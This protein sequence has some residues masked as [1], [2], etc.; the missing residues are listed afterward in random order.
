[1]RAL[2]LIL[3]SV[4]LAI[5]PGLGRAQQRV[6]EVVSPGSLQPGQ[7]IPPPQESVVLTVHGR[8]GET[9]NAAAVVF[10]LPMLEQIGLIRFT[11][12]TIWT[13]GPV[14]FE[15]ILVARLLEIL[16]VPKEATVAKMTAINDY[17][18]T[19]PLAEFHK[20]P[21]MIAL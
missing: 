12:T 8:L 13:T 11:T 19:I 16:A 4:A 5:R 18:V 1:M 21:V 6:Y 2:L 14:V 17:Q 3:A 10:D 20:W 9:H 15:G 7:P